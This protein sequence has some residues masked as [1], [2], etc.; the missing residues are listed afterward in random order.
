MSHIVMTSLAPTLVFTCLTSRAFPTVV[1]PL[2]ATRFSVAG[3]KGDEGQGIVWKGD[4]NALAPYV[5]MDAVLYNGSSYLCE[6]A[7]TGV[8]P[9]TEAN[10]S[11]LAAAG[12]P[13][14]IDG[15]MWTS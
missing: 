1:S 11:I 10:W 5:A 6:V 9:T 8:V 13:L 12:E 15:G 2:C 3:P 4:Y 14:D 7:C